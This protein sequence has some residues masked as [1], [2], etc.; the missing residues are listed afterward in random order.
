MFSSSRFIVDENEQ[1]QI[2]AALPA[3]NDAQTSVDGSLNDPPYA[4]GQ[5]RE[6]INLC[7]S[8]ESNTIRPAGS[9][10]L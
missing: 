9:H 6:E 4:F 3:C 10:S 7:T 1:F 5:S 2:P 8:C